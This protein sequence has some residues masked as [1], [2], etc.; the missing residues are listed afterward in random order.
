MVLI[1]SVPA[2]RTG[3]PGRSLLVDARGIRQSGI[4]RF[5]REVLARVV[6]DPRFGAIT[7]L[8]KPGEIGDFEEEAGCRGR[9]EVIPFPH[10]FYSPV[11]Q[12]RWAAL[13]ARGA[14]RRDAAFFPHYDVPLPGP[15]PRSVVTVQDLAHFSLPYFP[16]WKV[17]LGA[18]ILKRAVARAGRVL[19]P[20]RATADALV[21]RFPWAAAKV[22]AVPY[23]VDGRW[24][25]PV[26]QLPADVQ[27]LRPFLL[28]VGNRKPHK[29]HVAAVEALALLRR[30]TPE[31]RL[32]IVGSGDEDTREVRAR[33]AALGVGGAMVEMQGVSDARLRA[34]YAG[35]ECLLFP[36]LF[37][38]WGLPVLEAM[39]AGAPVVAS[40]AASIP[41]VVGDAGIVVDARDA[42]ALASAVER[43]RSEPG[44]RERLAS[45]GRAHAAGF[46][47]E[48]TAAR[49]A[50]LLW[51]VAAPPGTRREAAAVHATS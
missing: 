31:L 35:A 33:A 50:D 43:I 6:H 9:V 27:E 46:R 17:A 48:D 11:G 40:D 51:S 12:A 30:S 22:E 38:G 39:S 1:E 24:A 34:L 3:A 42:S 18:V 49:T 8:G 32:V 2:V 5:L 37:E 29:N 4:G 13:E 21:A 26:R 44:L 7:L 36:S 10:H 20:S 41:E 23:G 16:R 47:W 19:V 28:C 25:E 15:Q 45:R 14:L